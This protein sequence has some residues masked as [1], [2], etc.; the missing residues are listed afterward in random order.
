[1]STRVAPSNFTRTILL[2]MG[3]FTFAFLLGEAIHESGH[4]LAH[5]GF[6]NQGP[7]STW[8]PSMLQEPSQE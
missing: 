6:G 1:M 5:L 3:S 7:G 2:L 8:I 4:L